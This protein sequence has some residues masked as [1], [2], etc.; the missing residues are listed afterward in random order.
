[1]GIYSKRKEF[2]PLGANSFIEEQTPLWKGFFV[3]RNN[4]E[5]A[6]IASFWK[7][8]QKN[9]TLSEIAVVNTHRL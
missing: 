1:M 2:A 5:V 9:F 4:Q 7:K 8:W 6:E 3:L